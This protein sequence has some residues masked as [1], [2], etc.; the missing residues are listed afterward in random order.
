[1]KF[2]FFTYFTYEFLSIGSVAIQRFL[3]CYED[4]LGTVFVF[5]SLS[6]EILKARFQNSSIIIVNCLRDP[7]ISEQIADLSKTRNGLEVITSLKPIFMNRILNAIKAGDVLIYFDSD[8][9]FFERSITIDY[10]LMDNSFVVFQQ[11]GVSQESQRKYGKFNAGLVALKK[12]K[13]SEAL[14]SEWSMKCI[15]W[16]QLR[17]ENGKYADQKYLDAF[18]GR[19]GFRGAAGLGDNVSARAFARSGAKLRL[20]TKK[21]KKMIGEEVLSSYQFHGLR[22]AGDFIL[23]GI[24]RFGKLR[25]KILIFLKIYWPVLNEIGNVVFDSKVSQ[26]VNLNE[27]SI[28]AKFDK[29]L[30]YESRGEAN[31]TITLRRFKLFRILRLTLVPLG[32]IKLRKFSDV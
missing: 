24:N 18:S 19:D 11:L 25:G 1:M 32:L 6:E 28:F 7:S 4:S 16:C 13:D 26:V 17:A 22:T 14:L 29:T 15:D 31:S 20:R 8:L 2:H 21:G 3:N 30:V 9:I 10:L 12:C 23:T 5:D 27:V